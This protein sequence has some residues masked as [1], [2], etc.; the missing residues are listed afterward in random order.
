MYEN[1]AGIDFDES[2]SEAE[3]IVIRPRPGG[4]LTSA[5]GRYDSIRGSIESEWKLEGTRFELR[6]TVPVNARALVYV[7]GA[8]DEADGVSIAR[9]EEGASVLSVPSGR[10]R[11]TSRVEE[12]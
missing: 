7:P 3:R 9:E 5:R 2:A 6:V 4:G 1:V 8:I 12:P 11:F 10:Y